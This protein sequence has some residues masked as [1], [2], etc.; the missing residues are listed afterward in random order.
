[1]LNLVLFGPPG[2]GKGTQSEKLS[3][4][5]KLVHLSTGD[6][7]RGERKA[8]TELGLKAQKLIDA[9]MLVSDEIVTG[10]I[11]SKLEANKN[12]TGFIFDGFP[13]TIPQAEALD[14]ILSEKKTAINLTLALD[15][16]KEEL[17][18]RLLN[19]GKDSG[20]ADDQNPETIE[21]RIEVYHNETEPLQDY[22]SK[23]N[24]LKVIKGIGGIEAIFQKLCEAIDKA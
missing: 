11:I 4:K 1:M 7:L 15:V 23:Q 14:K 12:A 3:K 20:R 19:R 24:K 17:I 8:G 9:G 18:K 2:S 22:Y 6:I 21:K 16:E 13:R 5:Y 10:I